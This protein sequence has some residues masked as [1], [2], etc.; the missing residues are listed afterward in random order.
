V[1]WSALPVIGGFVE[2]LASRT[3]ALAAYIKKVVNPR[4]AIVFVIAYPHV[5]QQIYHVIEAARAALLDI[6]E[7]LW[8]WIESAFEAVRKFIDE[9]ISWI[10]FHEQISAAVAG[11]A[12]APA[13]IAYV[14]LRHILVPVAYAMLTLALSVLGAVYYIM[15]RVV[16]PAL[17]Y[18]FGAYLAYRWLPLV[19]RGAR[20]VVESFAKGSLTGVVAGFLGMTVPGVGFLA[21]P[22]LIDV[23]VGNA[24]AYA[25]TPLALLPPYAPPY[26]TYYP[27]VTALPATTFSVVP[28]LF[29]YLSYV[30]YYAP[31]IITVPELL[32]ELRP[33]VHAAVQRPETTFTLVP[34]IAATAIRPLVSGITPYI[35]VGYIPIVTFEL[36]PEVYTVYTLA[37]IP[38]YQ[39][40]EVPHAVFELWPK[41]YVPTG[42]AV[43]FSLHPVIYPPALVSIVV[44]DTSMIST[45]GG[46]ELAVIDASYIVY[47]HVEFEIPVVDVSYIATYG[48]YEILVTDVSTISTYG[49]LEIPVR[50]ASSISTTG[51]IEII[52]YD[53]SKIVYPG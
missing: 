33:E 40:P 38:T 27:A 53:A 26:V 11:F 49:G 28:A 14:V 13:V 1:A 37:Y 30:P 5:Y 24:C 46:I 9:R 41:V 4:F 17:R 2:F 29:V 6:S 7:Q 50:D 45:I 43:Y 44:T 47:P 32:S 21:G 22:A 10:P 31:Y 36:R 20:K 51:G 35:T 12:V 18:A 42:A 3:R 52:V 15:C 16:I 48:G 23:L 8:S 19:S 39:Y 25:V 34:Y